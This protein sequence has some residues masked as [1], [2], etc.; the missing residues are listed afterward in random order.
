MR[1]VPVAKGGVPSSTIGEPVPAWRAHFSRAAVA[2]SR[3]FDEPKRNKNA[4]RWRDYIGVQ[5]ETLE[6]RVRDRQFAIIR[7]AV[8]RIFDLNPI[9]RPPLGER[10]NAH[11]GAFEH[12]DRTRRELA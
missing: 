4:Q 6:V 1:T 5:S 9:K 2:F 10:Q 12:L 3:D 7:A 11:G 8:V